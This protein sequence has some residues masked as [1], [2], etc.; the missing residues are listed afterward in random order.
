MQ[1]DPYNA[2]CIHA[3]SFIAKLF[4]EE[5]YNYGA[6]A[7]VSS[8]LSAILPKQN[9]KTFGQDKIVCQMMK[10]IFKL[11]PLLPKYIVAYDPD[12]TLTYMNQLP[13]IEQLNLEVLIKKLAILLCLLSGQR[14]QSIQKLRLDYAS[15]Q[16]DKG[17]FYIPTA[18]KKSRPGK[19]QEP[20]N[21]RKTQKS[22]L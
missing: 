11:R 20:Q 21:F 9:G 14:W 22:A 17:E 16:N 15:F 1:L 3:T 13:K 5:N 6:L 12:V 7:V 19:H 4:H 18:L 10:G 8:A 2:D